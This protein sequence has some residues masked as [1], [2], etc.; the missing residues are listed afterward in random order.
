MGHHVSC[1]PSLP[2]R[3]GELQTKP[4]GQ[5]GQGWLILQATFSLPFAVTKPCAAIGV[6]MAG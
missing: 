3:L 6:G 1:R 2:I 4:N 5:S